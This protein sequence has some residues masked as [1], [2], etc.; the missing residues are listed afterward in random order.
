MTSLLHEVLTLAFKDLDKEDLLQCQLTSKKWRKASSK[1]VYSNLSVDTDERLDLYT[2]TVSKSPLLGKYLKKIYIG[3][4]FDRFGLLKTITKYCPNITEIEYYEQYMEIWT[5]LLNAASK[6]QL[7][8]LESLPNSDSTSLEYYIYTALVLKNSLTSLWLSDDGFEFCFQ[9]AD[10]K[11]YKL[12]YDQVDQFEKLEL[13]YINCKSNRY[14]SSLDVL[15]DK[16]H[17]LSY[18]LIDSTVFLPTQPNESKSTIRPRSD[19]VQT[20][21]YLIVIGN[22]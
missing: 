16:C 20:C 17:R 1:F 7:S 4:I 2:R 9:F 13:L 21:K 8:R 3:N 18:L 6:G 19:H 10:L 15:I 11:A 14:L 22:L 5:G 12:L